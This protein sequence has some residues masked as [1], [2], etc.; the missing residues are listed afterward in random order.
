MGGPGLMMMSESLYAT[1]YGYVY[2]Q[3]GLPQR[4]NRNNFTGLVCFACRYYLDLDPFT[5]AINRCC[6]GHTTPPFAATAPALAKMG[7]QFHQ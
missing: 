5:T 3:M 4:L 7:I 6:L 1:V 2:T